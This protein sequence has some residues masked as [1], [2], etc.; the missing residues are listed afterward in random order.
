MNKFEAVVGV[1]N[2]S[3][4]SD[5]RLTSVDPRSVAGNGPESRPLQIEFR[6]DETPNASRLRLGAQRGWLGDQIQ[7]TPFAPEVVRQ[8]P[9]V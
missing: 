9:P 6:T 4:P 3:G 5:N 7:S 8:A 1:G 2:N